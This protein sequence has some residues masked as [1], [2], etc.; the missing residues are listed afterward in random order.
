M[1][2]VAVL[3]YNVSLPLAVGLVVVPGLISVWVGLP[4]ILQR[5]V[6]Q[7]LADQDAQVD[8]QVGIH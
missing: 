6:D 1:V 7:S 8:D 4:C 3:P 5:C 2:G